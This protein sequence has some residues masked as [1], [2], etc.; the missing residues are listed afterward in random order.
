MQHS[1]P[2]VASLHLGFSDQSVFFFRADP[3]TNGA[4]NPF[5]SFELRLTV[6]AAADARELLIRTDGDGKIS[7]VEGFRKFAPVLAARKIF[8]FSIPCAELGMQ[9]GETA[10]LIVEI[11]TPQGA[12]VS[13]PIELHVPLFSG[14]YAKKDSE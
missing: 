3:E 6:K 5:A 12:G 1:Q 4:A 10:S 14:R 8:E 2:P 9:P 13:R 11:R 7:S